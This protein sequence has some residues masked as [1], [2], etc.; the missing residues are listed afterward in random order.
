MTSTFL[1]G[2]L[3]RVNETK[4]KQHRAQCL[5]GQEMLVITLVALDSFW[6]T[7]S[8]SY[9]LEF[10]KKNHIVLQESRIDVRNIRKILWDQDFI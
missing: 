1:T 8:L 7:S 5:A 3:W 9:T 10:E 4:D 2:L 6:Q